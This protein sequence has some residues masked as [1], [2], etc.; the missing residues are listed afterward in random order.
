MRDG[1]PPATL[2]VVLTAFCPR[3]GATRWPHPPETYGKRTPLWAE[4]TVLPSKTRS[5]S[6]HLLTT[7]RWIE[8][9]LFFREG[10]SPA[11]S[12][13]HG[14]QTYHTLACYPSSVI[15]NLCRF[16]QM[17]LDKSPQYGRYHPHLVVSLSRHS[18]LRPN[19]Y[20]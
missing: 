10:C 3:A 11:K 19:M 18:D 9:S 13:S 20:V 16:V 2:S 14:Q 4:L 12:T 7:A 5:Q 17:S 15:A 1:A 6:G 8:N